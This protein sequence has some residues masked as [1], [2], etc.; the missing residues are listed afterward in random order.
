MEDMKLLG[1]FLE[2]A[3]GI[4]VILTAFGVIIEVLL[5]IAIYIL[6]KNYKNNKKNN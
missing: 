1:W 3:K 4:D 6:Y 2:N 5:T